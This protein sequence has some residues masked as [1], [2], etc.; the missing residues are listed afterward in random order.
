MGTI[1]EFYGKQY[2]DNIQMGSQQLVA[3]FRDRCE[4][5]TGVVGKSKAFGYV[6]KEEARDK[7][8]RHSKVVHDDPNNVRCTAYLKYK[9][10]SIIQDPD[11]SLQVVADPKSTYARIPLAALNRAM[12]SKLLLAARGVK[13]TGEEGATQE[14]LPA[15]SKVA[16][17]SDGLTLAK[18]TS[19]LEKFNDADVNEEEAKFFAIGPKEVSQLLAIEKLTSAD[20]NT[21]KTLVPGKIVSFM[22][23]NFIVST[24]LAK[25]GTTRYC[26]AWA[27]SGLG[28]A[29]GQDI[30][31]RISELPE[32]HYAWG[33]Y[34]SMFIGATR[35]QDVK[36]VEI[37]AKE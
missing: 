5:K 26:M 14:A 6:E 11:D 21:V 4:V 16:V 2:E 31:G 17:G 23:F 22:G 19:T 7:N 37:G 30:V 1:N 33:A 20:Y 18:I 28:L 12:D 9:Y 8:A 15:A 36:V 32:Y 34:A 3:K 13:Y 24:L 25:S 35:I 27:Q 29:I 10:K